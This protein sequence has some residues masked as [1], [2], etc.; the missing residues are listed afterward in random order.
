VPTRHDF[1]KLYPNVQGIASFSRI[2][3]LGL[4]LPDS[5]FYRGKQNWEFYNSQKL[6]FFLIIFKV[7]IS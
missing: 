6:D 5:F 2:F 4:F 3:G 7:E 1:D